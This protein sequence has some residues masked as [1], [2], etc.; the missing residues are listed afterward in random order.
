MDLN[1]KRLVQHN[2][3]FKDMN[4]SLL[5]TAIFPKGEALLY[6]KAATRRT[7]LAMWISSELYSLTCSDQ[8]NR[9]VYQDGLIVYTRVDEY[10]SVL[11]SR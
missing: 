7:Q 9:S 10:L 5:Q 1:N 2:L 8:R 6:T 11:V 3:G 4:F